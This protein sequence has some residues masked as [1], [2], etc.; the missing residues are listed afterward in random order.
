MYTPGLGRSCL[1][2]AAAV[3]QKKIEKQQKKTPKR[4]R[5]QRERPFVSNQQQ[6]NKGAEARQQ[7]SHPPGTHSHN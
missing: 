3:W 7:E 5:I 6:M 4:E 1:D 2:V